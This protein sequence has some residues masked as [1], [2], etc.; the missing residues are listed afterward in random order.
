ASACYRPLLA[1]V[2]GGEVTE[3][4]PSL[5]TVGLGAGDELDAPLIGANH[6][7]QV[8]LVD[9]ADRVLDRMEPGVRR[10]RGECRRVSALE[11][12]RQLAAAD[13]GRGRVAGKIL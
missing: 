8:A 3:Q 4:A 5:A 2:R 12:K 10:D 9:P 13:L 11:E 1:E 7:R 6:G